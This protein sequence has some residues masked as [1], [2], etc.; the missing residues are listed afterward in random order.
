[1]F[2]ACSLAFG[3]RA[4]LGPSVDL[5]VQ[6]GEVLCVIGPNGAGKTTLFKTLLGLIKPIAGEVRLAGR[7]L[8]EMSRRE[9][10]QTLAYVP[11]AHSAY[12]PFSVA[13]VVLMGRV[14]HMGLLN[15]PSAHDRVAAGEALEKLRIAHLAEKPY[16]RISGGERQLVLVARALAQWPR[17]LIMDEPTANLDLGN[18]SRVLAEIVAL[19]ESGLSV[20]FSSHDP[21]HAFLCGDRVVMMAN[22][23]VIKVGAAKE[24]MTKSALQ[25]LYGAEIEVVFSRESDRMMCAPT[26]GGS[27]VRGGAGG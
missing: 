6:S 21:N 16:T 25:A 20:L 5:T 8:S 15:A 19:K 17:C 7:A 1:M 4:P 13:D 22:G 27:M 26:L 2:E 24:T 3:Y 18:Q 23:A 12:F 11:Q 14:A 9:I 10:A